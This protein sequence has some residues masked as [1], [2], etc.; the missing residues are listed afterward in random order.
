MLPSLRI[1]EENQG[2]HRTQVSRGPVMEC[3]RDPPPCLGPGP[4]A[5]Q[6]APAG[7]LWSRKHWVLRYQEQDL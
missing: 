2:T 3:A 5:R 7:L 6:C 4:Q 1:K